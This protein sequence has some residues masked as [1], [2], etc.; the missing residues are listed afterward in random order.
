[1]SNLLRNIPSVTEL[2]EKPPLQQI[3]NSLHRSVVVHHVR[4]FLDQLRSQVQTASDRIPIPG[5]SELAERIAAWILVEEVSPLRPV[6]NATGILL[7]TGL[8]R[9]P[10]AAEA[11]EAMGEIAAGYASVELD[12][13]SGQRS[14]RMRAVVPLLKELTGAEAAAVVNNNAGA[15]LLTLSAVAAGKEVIVS[16]GQLVEIGGSYRLPDVMQASGAQLKE[17]GTT[18]KTRLA[19]YENAIGPD[20]GALLQVHTSNYVIAGFSESTSL[21]DLVSLGQQHQLPV[22]DD[23]GSGALIDFQKFGIQ[24]EPTVA[25]SIRAGADLVLFSGD[26]LLGGPQCGI[27]V[28]RQ[29]WIEKITKHPLMRALRVDKV[30][31]AGLRATLQLYRDPETACQRVPLLTLLNT[32]IENLRQRAER[33]AP[34]LN[35]SAAIKDITVIEDITYLG[36]GS[37]PTQ[38]IAT[39]CL[40]LASASGS[41]DALAAQLRSGNIAVV[42]RIHQDRLLL[43]LRSMLASQ[44][45]LL[46]AAFTAL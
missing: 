22:I 36:G 7:H 21:P 26:K 44:D 41:I 19:D 9:A 3:T 32:S 29:R 1:M 11:I 46:V 28:G 37:V 23:I 43:D 33:L 38:A 2:L 35:E 5:A 8:G 16:R 6:V 17:I 40:S 24:D 14:Q 31:L 25:G 20:T 12:L 10:L 15:T 45:Q 27:I 39:C 30:T 18:N 4:G 42:G 34:Q 13:T